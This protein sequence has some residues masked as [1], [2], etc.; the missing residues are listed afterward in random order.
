[1]SVETQITLDKKS[2]QNTK[3]QNQ[4]TYVFQMQECL[5]DPPFEGFESVMQGCFGPQTRQF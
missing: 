1:M 5:L 3:Q 2:I 4:T